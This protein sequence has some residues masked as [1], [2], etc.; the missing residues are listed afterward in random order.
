MML[1]ISEAAK[2]VIG[3]ELG[4]EICDLKNPEFLVA[5]FG[6]QA[7][8]QLEYFYCHDL[9]A[10]IASG[11]FPTQ[12]MI[13]VPASTACF[14]RVANGISNSLIERAAECTIKESH[15]LVIVP[16]E[17]PLSEIHLENLLKLVRVGV[18]VVPAMP[19]F[20]SGC[21]S[22][23]EMVDFV[24]GKVLDQFEIEHMLYPRWTGSQTPDRFQEKGF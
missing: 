19:A 22:V 12:G 4:V 3:E 2:T 1:T 21:H 13:I 10:P 7:V 5:L 9:K 15:K 17:T 8:S 6:A 24:V 16:R 20:Y 23:E 11:S 18:R 14:S